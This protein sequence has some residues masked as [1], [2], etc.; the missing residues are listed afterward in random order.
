MGEKSSIDIQVID[1][2]DED[3]APVRQSFRIPVDSKENLSVVIKGKSYRVTDLGPEGIRI[4]LEDPL[5]FDAAELIEGSELTIKGCMLVFPDI[6]IKNLTA[7]II[8]FS[9]VQGKGL[10]NGIQWVNLTEE[11]KKKIAAQISIIKQR[12]L[13][14]D[15]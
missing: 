14:S 8:H 10:E 13:L 6:I 4:L 12:L 1:N 7:R 3:Q 2:E 15:T 5:D 11:N 9:L